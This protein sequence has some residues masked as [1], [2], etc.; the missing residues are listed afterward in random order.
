MAPSRRRSPLRLSS[1]NR[2]VSA[3]LLAKIEPDTLTCFMS[4]PRL[5]MKRTYCATDRRYLPS[6]HDPSNA[7]DP[8]SRRIGR[9]FVSLLATTCLC[10]GISSIPISPGTIAACQI[11]T[12]T[13]RVISRYQF[14][15]ETVQICVA[16]IFRIVLVYHAY[17]KIDL[18]AEII[19]YAMT[20]GIGEMLVY[21]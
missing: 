12:G 4:M 2:Y 17:L 15:F 13:I 16:R 11:I 9:A 21:A 19:V 8:E 14:P 7:R 1:K 10:I 18:L 20:T 3:D 5:P 6:G